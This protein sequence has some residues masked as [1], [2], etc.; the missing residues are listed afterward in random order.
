MQS[1]S[2]IT[3]NRTL[4]AF[5]CSGCRFEVEVSRSTMSDPNEFVAKR[6]KLEEAHKDCKVS[7]YLVTSS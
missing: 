3:F 5:V 4:H 2:R 7:P 1:A 6:E